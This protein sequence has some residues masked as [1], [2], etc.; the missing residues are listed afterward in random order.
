MSTFNAKFFFLIKVKAIGSIPKRFRSAFEIKLI[1]DLTAKHVDSLF[2]QHTQFFY[3]CWRIKKIFVEA[4]MGGFSCSCKLTD[5]KTH[6]SNKNNATREF[7]SFIHRWMD[8]WSKRRRGMRRKH[9]K[10]I[11]WR[12]R[13]L[14]KNNK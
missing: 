1:F 6:I 12:L 11:E 13:I 8:G 2:L 4:L 14:S 5:K 9:W 7:H 10:I 3:N